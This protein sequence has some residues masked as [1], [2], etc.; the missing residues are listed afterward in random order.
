MHYI[1]AIYDV[2]SLVFT[3]NYLVMNIMDPINNSKPSSQ[4]SSSTKMRDESSSIH[5]KLRAKRRTTDDAVGGGGA[6]AG[7]C[8]SNAS[9]SCSSSHLSCSM[10]SSSSC[11]STVP[12]SEQHLKHLMPPFYS[13]KNSNAA[14]NTNNKLLS[15]DSPSSLS[16]ISPT[17]SSFISNLNSISSSSN[18]FQFETLAL[19]EQIKQRNLG[20]EIVSTT[21]QSESSS[22]LNVNLQEWKGTRVLAHLTDIDGYLPACI[23]DVR[24][25]KDVIVQFDSGREHVFEDV[26]SRSSREQPDIVADQAPS[27]DSINVSDTLCVKWKGEESIYRLADVIKK[28]NSPARFQVRLLNQPLSENQPVWLPRANV[29]LMRPP[30]YDELAAVGSCNNSAQEN[31][32]NGSN[33]P[34]CLQTKSS[35][36]DVA[37]SDEDDEQIKDEQVDAVSDLNNF[38]GNSTPHSTSI[39]FTSN[40]NNQNSNNNSNNNN[41]N[42]NGNKRSAQLIGILHQASSSSS[43]YSLISPP[44]I[45]SD[46]NNNNNINNNN[47]NDNSNINNSNIMIMDDES[48]SYQQ[49]TPTSSN[50]HSSSSSSNP[51]TNSAH[52]IS[53]AIAA[54]LAMQ[55]QQRYKKGEIVTTPG[56]IRKKFNGKQW[57]RLCSK[58]GCN[59]ESQRRGYCSRHL[60]LKGKSIRS[61]AA[62]N[63]IAIGLSSTLSSAN[64]SAAAVIDWRRSSPTSSSYSTSDLSNLIPTSTKFD[65]NDIANTLLNLRNPT[66]HL[67]YVGVNGSSAAANSFAN[68]TQFHLNLSNTLV[69]QHNTSSSSSSYP[70]PHDLLPLIDIPLSVNTAA[71]DFIHSVRLFLLMAIINLGCSQ[72]TRFRFS[73]IVDRVCGELIAPRVVGTMSTPD[74]H[75]WR[76]NAVRPLLTNDSRAVRCLI[77]ENKC[78]AKMEEDDS[79]VNSSAFTSFKQNF[80]E[81]SSN[82]VDNCFESDHFNYNEQTTAEEDVNFSLNN[83]DCNNNDSNATFLLTPPSS[84]INQTPTPSGSSKELLDT[85]TVPWHQLVPH[86]QKRYCDD[87]IQEKSTSSRH[88]PHEIVIFNHHNYSFVIAAAQLM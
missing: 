78:A 5:P 74:V 32:D 84:F 11:S 67:A 54:S 10:S 8:G 81:S 16:S 62:A 18:N 42:S 15:T 41:N 85:T 82:G 34:Q 72:G 66:A 51:A 22:D 30:W 48:S 23:K 53:T 47:N 24:N 52:H 29:R 36:S 86:L 38:S 33:T 35:S 17:Q 79:I 61:E 45:S 69:D 12:S 2:L 9:R 87:S 20:L 21:N 50:L 26:M 70:E 77:D 49:Q 64:A 60:S 68:N 56:G 27:P 14:N 75:S 6:A 46:S 39:L 28:L 76:Q 3:N 63:A 59:K 40:S 7:A 71:A 58:E 65:E 43:Q 73:L 31:R 80:I 25:N 44:S 55:Q 19:M 1:R 4:S 37:D 13:Y 88:T 57:R 83:T